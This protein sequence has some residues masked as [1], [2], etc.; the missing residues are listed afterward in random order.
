MIDDK[1]INIMINNAKLAIAKS[2]EII[3]NNELKFY[4]RLDYCTRL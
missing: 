3:I 1:A 2:M 4:E